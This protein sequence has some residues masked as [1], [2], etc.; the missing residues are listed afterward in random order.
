MDFSLG[1]VLCDAN[2]YYGLISAPKFY[3]ANEN[4]RKYR[5]TVYPSI[6]YSEKLLQTEEAH[7]HHPET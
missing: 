5:S 7:T 2:P 4:M 6:F 1:H 3:M